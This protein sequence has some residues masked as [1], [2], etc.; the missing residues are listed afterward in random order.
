M[1]RPRIIESHVIRLSRS[2]PVI[3]ITGA[4]QTGKTTLL[5]HLSSQASKKRRYVSLDEL[6]MRAL[7]QNDPSLFFQQFPPPV[8]IDEIQ[9]AP[10]LLHSV[11]A[12]VDR[13]P[14]RNGAFWL[15][16]SQQFH[17]MRHVSESLAGR[18]GLITLAGL[19]QGEVLPGALQKKPWRPGHFSAS[20][21]RSSTLGTVFRR[22]LKGSFPRL[23]ITRPPPLDAFFRSYLQTYVDRDLREMVKTSSLPSFEKFVRLCAARTASMLNLSDL[24]RDSEAAVNTVKEWLGLLEASHLVYLLRPYYRNI[25]KRLIK[26]P[27]LYFLDTGLACYLTGWRN[28]ESAAHGAMSGALFETYVVAEILKSHWHRGLEPHIYYFRTKEGLEVDIVL[29]ESGRLYPV[30]AKL[31]SRVKTSELRGLEGLKRTGVPLGHG[32]VASVC[33]EPYALSPQV[34]VLPVDQIT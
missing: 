20:D 34:S 1:Y 22:I 21:S 31:A 15:S 11:K 16:G 28:A 26:A 19:S 4:R 17:L 6:E 2:F 32:T 23:W 8:I 25:S 5:K 33:R 18:V 29:E 13:H 27:K 24:A 7:A 9:N 3:L 14:D 30:E 12:E 10:Q